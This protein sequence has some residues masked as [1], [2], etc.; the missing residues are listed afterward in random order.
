[1][2]CGNDVKRNE[3]GHVHMGFVNVV[4]CEGVPTEFKFD[5]MKDMLFEQRQSVSR[6]AYNTNG[7]PM[8]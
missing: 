2:F 5:H 7:F 1:M 3:M 6:N 8:I 4:F